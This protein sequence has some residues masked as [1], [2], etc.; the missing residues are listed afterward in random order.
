M[1]NMGNM[2]KQAQKMQKKMAE[3]QK[4]LALKTCEAT[5]GGG[6]VTA[7]VNGDVKL[8]SIK[9]DPSVVDPEDVEMLED[10]VVA[11][12]TEASKRAQEMVNEEMGK[13]TAGLGIEPCACRIET[14][15]G[16]VLQFPI[17]VAVEPAQLAGRLHRIPEGVAA[18]SQKIHR[19]AVLPRPGATTFSPV[20]LFQELGCRRTGDLIGFDA[21][22]EDDRAPGPHCGNCAESRFQPAR[23]DEGDVR[24]TITDRIHD[25]HAGEV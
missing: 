20:G 6:M 8:E 23:R 24:T 4:E 12:V 13:L 21:R 17:V 7:V 15:D 5:A 1:S 11:A 16:Y 10:L 14:P 25:R 22:E 3:V 19:G 9:I 18:R 2:M